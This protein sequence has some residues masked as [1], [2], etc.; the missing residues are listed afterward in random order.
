MDAVVAGGLREN[1]LRY[2][3][4]R[5]GNFGDIELASEDIV[6]QAFLAVLEGPRGRELSENFAYM[7]RVCSTVAFRIYR[8]EQAEALARAGGEDPDSLPGAEDPVSPFLDEEAMS[9]IAASLETLRAIERVIIDKRYWG[10]SSFAQIAR[11]TGL[12]L[13]T[14]LSHHRRA[15]ER[16]RPRLAAYFG[17]T[18]EPDSPADAAREG[19]ARFF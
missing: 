8:S 2:V 11:D 19:V 10:E 13:N 16:L 14:V 1:L 5:F 7:S 15:L 9:A 3:R 12:N 17:E 4:R 18:A 6:D